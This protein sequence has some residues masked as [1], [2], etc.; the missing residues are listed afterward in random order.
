V[1]EFREKKENVEANCVEYDYTRKILLV[2][3]KK[4]LIVCRKIEDYCLN[5]TSQKIIRLEEDITC[6]YIRENIQTLFLG[7]ADGRILH[8]P[9]PLNMN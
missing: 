9:Y 4:C 2:G 5:F 8:C 1:S 7:T 3:G 6:V